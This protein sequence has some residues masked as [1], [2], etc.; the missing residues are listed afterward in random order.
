VSDV[1]VDEL[2]V[3]AVAEKASS[4]RLEVGRPVDPP[5]C[6][7]PAAEDSVS[8]ICSPRTSVKKSRL[9]CGVGVLISTCAS[10]GT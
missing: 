5:A 6:A 1:P 10:C 8:K 9:A 3:D 4:R 2:A 7:S